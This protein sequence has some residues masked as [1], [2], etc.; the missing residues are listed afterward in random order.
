V[1]HID[2]AIKLLGGDADAARR[3]R[4]VAAVEFGLLAPLLL[5]LLTGIVEIGMAGYQAMQVQAAV[6][7]GVLYAAKNGAS[8]L[9]GVTQAV[10]NATGTAGVTAS[11]APLAFCGCPTTSG[12]VSQNSD[13][14]TPCSDGKAPSQ[15]VK[16][17]AA[18]PH[19]TIMPFLTLPI[20]ASMTAQS[21]VR[22]K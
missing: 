4:G 3:S 22:V 8:D 21:T 1:R 7:A 16:V 18:V 15:Y 5:I 19:Q 9:A 13:C 20:P 10:L 14:T 6:E 12:V 17:S 2:R 11:P